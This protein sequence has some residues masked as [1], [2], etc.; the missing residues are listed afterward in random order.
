MI[1]CVLLEG[2]CSQQSYQV[3]KIFFGHRKAVCQWM[4]EFKIMF[5]QFIF[6]FVDIKRLQIIRLM[7]FLFSIQKNVTH[8]KF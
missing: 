6:L 8:N 3:K 7:G 1:R 4:T 5:L 2:S